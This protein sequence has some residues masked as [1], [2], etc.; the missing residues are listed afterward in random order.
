ME[1]QITA[2][3]DE[4]KVTLTKAD[5]KSAFIK[6]YL[7][8]EVSNSYERLQALA[9][10][11]CFGNILKKLYPKKEDLVAG[12]KRHMSFYNSE[13]TVGCLIHG[14]TCSMEEERANGG[15][16]PDEAITG[17]K[18][19]L[20][21]PLAGIGDTLTWGTWRPI[22]LAL[23]AAFAMSGNILGAFIPLLF[24][25]LPIFVSYNLWMGG[26][27]MGRNY[28]R[29]LLQSGMI[30]DVITASSIMGIFM[31]GALGSSYVK[32]TIPIVVEM[33]NSSPLVIQNLL[34]EIAPGLLP[35]GCIM[36][37]YLFFKKKGQSY[38]VVIATILIVS[39]IGSL[40][41]LF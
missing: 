22:V 21:G 15:N 39:L 12:L 8:A 26:Y 33:E 28:I 24:P 37:I 27:S 14:V 19:G 5:L 41:G 17:F 20:M 40:V 13:G 31:M 2:I 23:S 10:C 34:N 3:K 9:F 4:K 29:S 11:A 30:N 25:V 35:L 32:L 16:V 6:W 18:T 36:L 1:G 38:N 7:I